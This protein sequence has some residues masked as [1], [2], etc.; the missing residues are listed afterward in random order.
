VDPLVIRPPEHQRVLAPDHNAG[1]LESVVQHFAG[2]V[3]ALGLGMGN[4]DRCARLHHGE[5][6]AV[7]VAEKLRKA[8]VIHV[9]VENARGVALR[10]PVVA[11]I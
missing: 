10:G 11:V 1:Q 7:E 6:S 2:E 9:V 8:G 5:C 4:V 3:G